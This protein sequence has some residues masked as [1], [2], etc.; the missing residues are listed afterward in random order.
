MIVICIGNELT[1]KTTFSERLAQE[2]QWER[3]KCIRI[4]SSQKRPEAIDKFLDMHF[5]QKHIIFDR[6]YF[7][8]DIVYEPLFYKEQST[9]LPVQDI[10]ERK[11]RRLNTMML[12][13][14]ADIKTLEM[15]Y[16]KRGDEYRTL[17]DLK[18]IDI[19]YS[20][21]LATTSIPYA[22]IDTTSSTPEM[23]YAQGLK[24][25]QRYLEVL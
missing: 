14:K 5:T 12:Y 9:L 21:F 7:P 3:I 18:K 4:P 13:F 8:D 2:L 1:G 23:D 16:A 15:R 11:L 20:K 24:I 19:G 25:I 10:I 22:V 17:Q 6:W